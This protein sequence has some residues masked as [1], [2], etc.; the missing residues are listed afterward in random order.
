VA[1]GSIV[2]LRRVLLPCAIGSAILVSAL[3]A[4]QAASA[5]GHTWDV[6]QDF[7]AH[8]SVNP[9]PDSYGHARV[10]SWLQ[11][12][13]KK[14]STDKL[15]GTMESPSQ[16]LACGLPSIQSWS[17]ST[18]NPL[19]LVG[20]NS[21]AAVAKGEDQCDATRQLPAHSVF[22]HPAPST[23][24]ILAWTAPISATVT[25]SG[26]LVDAD[27]GGGNGIS[28]S[29]SEGAVSLASGKF[30]NGKSSTIGPINGV[31]VTKG[32]VLY[33]AINAKQGN[34]T[35]DTTSVSLTITS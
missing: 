17:L 29:V 19:P 12:N 7:A 20:L 8:P 33:L 34:D 23:E 9:V 30:V 3:A 5:A 11:G 15:L 25:I 14:P 4:P 26:S 35:Y 2:R 10:W 28:W 6:E 27:A 18:A 1:F 21:G 31:A 16:W 22:A 32:Q 13:A 24:V